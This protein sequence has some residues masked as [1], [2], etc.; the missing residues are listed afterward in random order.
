MPIIK[1][2]I[3]KM[4]Q[5]KVRT[6]RNRLKR[7]NLRDTIKAVEDAAKAGADNLSELLKSAFKTIDKSAK[8]NLLHENNA[9][10]KKSTLNRLV[11]TAASA[12]KKEAPAKKAP[13]KK[14]AAK[15]E[16]K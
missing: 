13:A 2:A 12:P 16:T 1:S 5:D 8:W 3:K 9:A 6:A 14:A 10:R 11:K 15:V 7:E 4:R